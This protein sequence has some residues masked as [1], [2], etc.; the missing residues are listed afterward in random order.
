MSRQQNRRVIANVTEAQFEAVDATLVKL[1]EAYDLPSK[2]DAL[3]YILKGM[4]RA[5]ETEWPEFVPTTEGRNFK[6]G[7]GGKFMKKS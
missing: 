3:V 1:M 7:A 2:N 5:T 4:C 6:K